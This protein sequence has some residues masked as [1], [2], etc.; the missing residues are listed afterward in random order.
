MGRLWSGAL[1]STDC[2]TAPSPAA[3]CCGP[4]LAE[5]KEKQSQ[6]SEGWHSTAHKKPLNE[7]ATRETNPQWD[8]HSKMASALLRKSFAR[9]YPR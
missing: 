2:A 5:A 6:D 7:N 4:S 1:L 8:Y 3:T 9:K